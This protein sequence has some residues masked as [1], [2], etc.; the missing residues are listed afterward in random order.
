MSEKKAS[1]EAKMGRLREIVAWFESDDFVIEQASAK[2]EAA[3]TLAAEIEH[4]L[5]QLKNTVSVLKQ[6]FEEK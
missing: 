4:D 3:A 5:S 2:F 1:V 6:S